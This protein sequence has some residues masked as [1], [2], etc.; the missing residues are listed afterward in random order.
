MEGAHLLPKNFKDVAVA[1]A[2][3]LK[4]GLSAASS[5]SASG[6]PGPATQPLAREDAA[7]DPPSR[8]GLELV[9]VQSAPEPLVPEP[10]PEPL[11]P[12]PLVGVSEDESSEP[13]FDPDVPEHNEVCGRKPRGGLRTPCRLVPPPGLPLLRGWPGGGRESGKG[14]HQRVLRHPERKTPRKTLR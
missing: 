12:E 9:H 10:P 2:A 5:A 4:A 14:W 11:V 1:L 3:G 8:A 7:A 13:N 6:G